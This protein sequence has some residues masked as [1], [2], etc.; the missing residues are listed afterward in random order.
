[1][2]KKIVSV[3][4]I[5]GLIAGTL[6]GCGSSEPAASSDATTLELWSWSPVQRTADKMIA[7]FEEENPDIKVNFSMY[8]YNP[9]YLEAIQAATGSGN[10]PDIMALHP[11]SDC[12][13]YKDYL[14]D[15]GSY[16]SETWGD[17]WTSNYEPVTESQLQM[18]NAE[19]DD[20]YRIIPIETQDIYIEYNKALFDSLNIAAPTTYDELVAV[21][22]T[23]RDNDLAPLFFGGADGW[24]HVNLIIMCASQIDKGLFDACQNGEKDWT[25]DEMVQAIEN[26][27]KLFDD[28][29][30]QDN[31]LSS[32]SYSDGTTLFLAGKVGMMALGSWW[33]QEFTSEDEVT[34]AVANWDYD[35]FYLPAI[36]KGAS[37]SAPIGGVDF[38]YGIT[39]TC[40]NPDAAWTAVSSFA[41]GVGAQ[42]IADDMNNHLSWPGIVPTAEGMTETVAGRAGV[43]NAIAEFTKSGKDIEGGLVNQR[44]AS[45]SVELA[46]QEAM[47]GLVAGDY[48]PEQAAKHIQEAQDAL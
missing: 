30:M 41:A 8:N 22:K 7:A 24:Q 47:Q 48:T 33:P 34:D 39:N 17:D 42:K 37:D 10:L 43:D 35:Y 44:L 2:L 13:N 40:E 15:L 26:Y 28:G 25:C 11:G 5:T 46:I 6:A 45:P 12:Q 32:T 36:S 27:K 9:E 14:L 20:A 23:L 16:A 29:V 31:C 3:I 21:A 18:G 1:M 4:A 19:G 38:G